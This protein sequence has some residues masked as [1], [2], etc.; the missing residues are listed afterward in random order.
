[1]DQVGT[2]HHVA[3]CKDC[4][5]V[6]KILKGKMTNLMSQLRTKHPKIHE[7]MRQKTDEK[8]S[9]CKQSNQAKKFN[10][11]QQATLPGIAASKTVRQQHPT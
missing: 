2:G 5:K 10:D 4:G 3:S 1:M 11:K 8:K 9:I 6:V 7:E